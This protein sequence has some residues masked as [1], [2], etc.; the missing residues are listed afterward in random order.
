MS[1]KCTKLW[2]VFNVGENKMYLKKRVYLHA[3]MYM[4]HLGP[5]YKGESC[6]RREEIPM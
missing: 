5:P 4:I 3:D 6:S 1:E 2:I